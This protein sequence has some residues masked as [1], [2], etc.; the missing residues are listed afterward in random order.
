MT[1]FVSMCE[2]VPKKTKDVWFLCT[3]GRTFNIFNCYFYSILA[4][5]YDDYNATYIQLKFD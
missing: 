2:F 3:C 5:E 4:G 1:K